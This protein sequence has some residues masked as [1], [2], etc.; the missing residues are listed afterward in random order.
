MRSMKLD[1]TCEIPTQ[2]RNRTGRRK[3]MVTDGPFIETKELRG[4]RYDSGG[5]PIAAGRYVDTTGRHLAPAGLPRSLSWA[6][7][8]GGLVLRLREG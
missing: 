3:A 5:R 6:S 1:R 2:A 7:G 8:R 4:G